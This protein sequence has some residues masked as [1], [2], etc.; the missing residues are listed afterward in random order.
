[1]KRGFE[2]S[3]VVAGSSGHCA[4]FVFIS[5]EDSFQLQFSLLLFGMGW[6][7]VQKGKAR[8]SSLWW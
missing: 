3:L 6:T 7:G 2:A 8:S 4:K 5:F 1:M